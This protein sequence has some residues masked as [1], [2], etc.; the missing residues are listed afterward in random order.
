MPQ[1]ALSVKE[2]LNRVQRRREKLKLVESRL[3][4]LESVRQTLTAIADEVEVTCSKAGR[5]T[6]DVAMTATF[7]EWPGDND[8]RGLGERLEWARWNLSQTDGGWKL[9]T[10]HCAQF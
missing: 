6:V 5:S 8:L 3:A 10:R 7:D 9:R 2:T 4:E 1:G